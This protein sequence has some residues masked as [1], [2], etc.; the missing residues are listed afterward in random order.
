MLVMLG[1]ASPSAKHL[2]GQW[3]ERKEQESQMKEKGRIEVSRFSY[4]L[5]YTGP[6]VAVYVFVLSEVSGI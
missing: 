4:L 6:F 1:R 2:T 5:V 3:V